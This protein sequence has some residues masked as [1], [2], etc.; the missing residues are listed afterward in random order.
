VI[1][2]V[3]GQDSGF[4]GLPRLEPGAKVSIRT[5]SGTLT[6]TVSAATL[7]TE[8]GLPQDPLFTR[9]KPGRLVLLGIRYD[10]AGDRLGKALVVTAQLSGATPS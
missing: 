3:L 4:A 7:R 9:H 10:D 6:Y 2:K 5:D 1:G 8:D